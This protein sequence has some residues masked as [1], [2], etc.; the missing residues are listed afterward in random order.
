MN[1]HDWKR[2]YIDILLGSMARH[3]WSFALVTTSRD[4]PNRISG[5]KV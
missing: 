1:E 5:E 3:G 4:R 2:N